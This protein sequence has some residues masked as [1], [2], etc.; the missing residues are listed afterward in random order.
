MEI[1]PWAVVAARYVRLTTLTAVLASALMLTALGSFHAAKDSRP[2][3]V[4]DQACGP[5]C[6]DRLSPESRTLV[7]QATEAG[8]TCTSTPVLTDHVVVED[9]DGRARVVD[10]DTAYELAARG[11]T[12]VRRYC[13]GG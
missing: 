9:R 4:I 6:R 3:L 8:S 5:E 7:R 2:V 10:F 1:P 11:D 13:S 12:W